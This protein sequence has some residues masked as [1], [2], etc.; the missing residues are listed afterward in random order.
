MY[1]YICGNW[2]VVLDVPLLF[3]SGMDVI[4][5]TVM[6]VAVKDDKIQME[7]LRSR[8]A[9][10]S[11]EDAENRVKSQGD[12]KGKVEKAEYRGTGNARGIVVWND[13]DRADLENEVR[14]A[15]AKVA[16]S[17]PR[18]WAWLLLLVPPI[19]VSAALWDLIVNF[20]RRKSWE[21]TVRDERAKL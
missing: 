11:A 14:G 15:M 5:G 16:A 10:L 3:E 9:H 21:R 1:H 19:G 8:D 7:R 12:V 18:W 13:G 4:C 20:W 2:A 17:S 6:V